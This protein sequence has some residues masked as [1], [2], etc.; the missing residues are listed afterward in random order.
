MQFPKTTLYYAW[1]L[2]LGLSHAYAGS[3]GYPVVDTGQAACYDN[4]SEI[5]APDAGTAFYGQDAQYAGN[6]PSYTV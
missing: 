5:T 4:T 1:T 2:L 3:L 6:Q